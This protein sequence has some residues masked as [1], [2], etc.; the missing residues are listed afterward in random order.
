MNDTRPR[1]DRLA[2]ELDITV[3]RLAWMQR[4]LAGIA[5][6]VPAPPTAPQPAEPLPVPTAPPIPRPAAPTWTPAPR[7]SAQPRDRSW[8]VARVLAGGGAVVTSTGVA[9]LL[10]LAAEAG[11]LGPTVRVG[12]GAALAAGLVAAAW[13]CHRRGLRVGEMALSATGCAAAY[14]DVV[15]VTGIYHWAAHPVGVAAAGLIALGGLVLAARWRSQ[16]LA[17]LVYAPAFVLAPPLAGD[18][19]LLGGF[20]LVLAAA[21]LPLRRPL[22][23]P[24]LHLV[25][26]V[27]TAV[28]LGTLLVGAGPHD[29]PAALG[30]VVAGCVI[31]IWTASAR[32]V[33]GGAAPLMLAAG[34]IGVVPLFAAPATA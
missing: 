21:T 24:V 9:L 1:L 14:L 27:G 2:V 23:W 15:A 11:L 31:E 6:A 5:A 16:W 29:A 33:R 7:P 30:A 18:G 20:T 4:E 19:Y 34:L 12:L 3:R 25:G 13:A 28:T 17:I 8:T 32:A 26:A 10:A 22:Q